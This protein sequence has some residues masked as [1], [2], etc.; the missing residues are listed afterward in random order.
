MAKYKIVGVVN[1]FFGFFEVVYP[2]IV[3][4]FTIPRLTELYSEF[5]TKGPNL[6]PIYIILSIVI[7][8]GIGN[9]FLG[10]KLFSISENKDKYFKYAII[11][12]VINF[13]LG[14]IFTQIVSL[15]VL[16]PIYNLTSEF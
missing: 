8:I 14:G 3:I 9:F 7:L 16:M 10:V 13:L 11:L 2:L 4:L 5:Q 15:S 12:I 1:F 6:I